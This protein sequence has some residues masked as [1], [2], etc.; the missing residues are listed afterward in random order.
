MADRDLRAWIDLLEAEG[1]LKRIKAKVD[2]NDEIAQIIR[3]VDEQDGRA[4]LFENIKGHE[5]TFSRRLF[6]NSLANRR[7]VI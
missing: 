6:S 7:R 4:L 3:R 2:W 1:E 5:N